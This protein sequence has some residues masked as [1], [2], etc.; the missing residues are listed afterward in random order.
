MEETEDPE[1]LSGIIERMILVARATE[2]EVA[3]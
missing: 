2:K 1:Q 3:S